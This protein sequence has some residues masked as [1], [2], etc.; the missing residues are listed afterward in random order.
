MKKAFTLL[1]L[2][3]VMVVV[4]IISVLL[5]PR[6]AD[7]KLTEA[8]DQII[9]HIRYTQHLAM[10]DDR[11]DPSDEFWYKTR[12]QI[13]FRQC[14]EDTN[15][16]TNKWYYVVG[17]DIDKNGGV[18]KNGSAINPSDKKYLF[19]DNQCDLADDES[20]EILIYKKYSINKIEFAKACGSNQYI[21]FDQLGRPYQSTLSN[22]SSLDLI[23]GPCEIKFTSDNGDFTITIEPE[24]GYTHLSEIN[25]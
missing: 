19:T 25:Y 8:A 15:K 11:F 9:S 24:T 4:S 16:D 6:F 10:I 23:H 14:T 12:W 18:D 13:S 2:V 7:S 21:S 22:D 17:R 5:I 20:G 1:E 3:I